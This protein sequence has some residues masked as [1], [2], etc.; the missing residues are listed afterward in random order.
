MQKVGTN[1]LKNARS[2]EI[3]TEDKPLREFAERFGVELVILFG[4]AAKG[5]KQPEDVDIALV[6]SEQKRIRH[7]QDMRAYSKLWIALGKTL[8]VSPDILD[9]TFISPK[10]PPF[11]LF[12][13]ARD[14]KRLF[15]DAAKFSAF[16]L[17][18][19]KMFF[20]AAMFRR[21]RREYIQK[22]FYGR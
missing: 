2:G 18:A 1:P 22:F 12:S 15:G 3:R 16:R 6:L 11:L 10:T 17:K 7:E 8:G 9:I 5:Q 13:I 21:A 14:G 19:V 4:S 20:D